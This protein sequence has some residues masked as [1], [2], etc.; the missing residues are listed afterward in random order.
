MM[1]RRWLGAFCVALAVPAGYTAWLI[2]CGP[3]AT[4]LN[5]RQSAVPAHPETYR[6]GQLG[7]VRPT[8]DLRYLVEAYRVVNGL[9][10]SADPP[11]P[12]PVQATAPLNDWNTLQAQILSGFTAA[13]FTPVLIDP[14]RRTKDYASFLNCLDDAFVGA[15]RT[16]QAR[17]AR[18]GATSREVADWLTGQ[19]AVFQNCSSMELVLPAPAPPW[20][21]RDLVADREYQTAVAYF[22]ATQ[23]DEAARRF[24][25]IAQSAQSSWRTVGRYLAGRA[26]IRAA[27]V[28]EDTPDQPSASRARLESAQG[29]F[30]AV[31][32]DPSA[33]ALH[34]STRGLLEFIAAKLRPAEQLR[35][36]AR[37]L[38]TAP[39]PI[40]Q[41]FADFAWLTFR[42]DVTARDS[43]LSE[44]IGGMRGDGEQTIARW[45]DT[46]STPWLVAALWRAPIQHELVPSLLTAA[47][48]VPQTS[49]VYA[50]VAFLRV[51]L[52]IRRGDLAQARRVLATLPVKPGANIDAEVLNLI[53][54]ERFALAQSLDELLDNA[55]R[56][57][58]SKSNDMVDAIAIDPVKD[59]NPVFDDDAGVTFNQRLTLERLVDAAE[60]TRL[61]ARLRRRIAEAAFARAVVLRRPQAGVRTAR[62]LRQLAPVLRAD[63]DRYLAASS[64]EARHRA[65]ILLLLR[66]PGLHAT[67]TG[68]EGE[69]YMITAPSPRQFDHVYRDNWWCVV[70][71]GEPGTIAELYD[72]R[73]IP[74]PSFLPDAEHA[75]VAEEIKRIN[76][77]G[78]A[79]VYLTTEAVAWARATPADANVADA[80]AQAVESWRWSSCDRGDTPPDL[81]R[82]AFQTLHRLFPKSPAA[83]RTKY[84]YR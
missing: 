75:A 73:P 71:G 54:A 76:A 80:L 67:V 32:K 78:P 57:I 33:S 6:R 42:T 69:P 64:D 34:P 84:W 2:A 77:A 37:R 41:D 28:P 20:A 3:S 74:F 9:R 43:E 46:R 66:T 45:R 58:V 26:M 13:P 72:T 55:P 7:L 51:R 39:I 62:V 27:T 44:W 60:S 19:A 25:A 29:D 24:R 17:V 79:L 21:D 5:P 8:F 36:V 70:G 53:R 52:L 30:Q 47:A 4:T 12:A 35:A 65:G 48:D 61:P 1:Y 22:Y 38:A 81:P 40:E 83:A 23:Y 14:N 56:T 82:Q 11:A 15:T 50:T 31:L 16:L 18:Y 68:I 49:P 63:L 59:A 10:G